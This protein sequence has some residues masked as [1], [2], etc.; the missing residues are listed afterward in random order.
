MRMQRLGEVKNGGRDKVST[1]Y[2]YEFISRLV[3]CRKSFG[4]FSLLT[5]ELGQVDPPLQLDAK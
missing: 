5:K 1:N 4:V 2:A 3:Y